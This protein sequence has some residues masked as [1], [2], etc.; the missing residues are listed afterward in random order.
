VRS[1]SQ[2]FEDIEASGMGEDMAKFSDDEI[3]AFSTTLDGAK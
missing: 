1:D 2:E 3:L